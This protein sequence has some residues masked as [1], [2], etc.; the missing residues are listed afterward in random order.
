[1]KH[2]WL[3]ATIFAVAVMV[4]CGGGSVSSPTS[5]TGG[6]NPPPPS[7]QVSSVST[8]TCDPASILVGGTSQ[9]SA[10]PNVSGSGCKGTVTWSLSPANLGTVTANGLVTGTAAGTATVTATSTDDTTKSASTTIVI[11][12]Q[13]PPIGI[14]I[15]P[16]TATVVGGGTKQF[17]VSV[18][19]TTGFTW[20]LMPSNIGGSFDESGLF[21]APLVSKQ[22]AMTIT[23]STLDGSKQASASVTVTPNPITVT[24]I[25][26][27]HFSLD[28]PGIV[29]GLDIQGNGFAAGDQVCITPI[30]GCTTNGSNNPNLISFS[31]SIDPGHWSPGTFSIQVCS[32]D[33]K[34]E[35]STPS[36]NSQ[37]VF[38]GNFNPAAASA[39]NM[40]I[41]AIGAVDSFDLSNGSQEAPLQF[42]GSPVLTVDPASEDLGMLFYYGNVLWTDENG[43]QLG[44]FSDNSQ[45]IGTKDVAA[46]NRLL[47]ITST[48]GLQ[49][50][51]MQQ[52]SP[53]VASLPAGTDPWPLAMTP[54]CGGTNVLPYD[55]ASGILY[56]G[57]VSLDGSGNAHVSLVGTSTPLPGFTPA[58]TLHSVD[59]FAGNWY[60]AAF[61]SSCGGAVF[62]TVLNADNSVSQRLTF[63]DGNALTWGTPVILPANAFRIAADETHGAVIV[64]YDDYANQLMRFESVSSAGVVTPLT[65]TCPSAMRGGGLA[66]SADGLSVYCANRDQFVTVPNQ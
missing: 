35:C 30:F 28:S 66:V 59:P 32:A 42:G 15:T 12:A 23:V 46:A 24:G 62:D 1:M 38:F 49:C 31:L 43:S 4:G 22:T 17:T 51:N 13:Q 18:T 60:A 14:S 2:T 19:G 65:N 21:T 26:P 57:S 48:V 36:A 50:V 54:A 33:G 58:S 9:C 8:P 56:D 55:R 37:L 41:D 47:C 11:T 16:T 6:Q 63:F 45:G 52:V 27:N 61:Q 7:C 3:F 25:S 34:S 40:F 44:G 53:T 10:K 39:T 64:A 5:G 29:G 20:A